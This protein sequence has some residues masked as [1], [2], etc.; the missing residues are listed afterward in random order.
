MQDSEIRSAAKFSGEGQS[1][2]MI[3]GSALRF[4]QE[5]SQQAVRDLKK[6]RQPDLDAPLGITTEIKLHSPAFT[7]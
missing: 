2:E 6:G 7:A 1:G 5:C 4:I 3:L